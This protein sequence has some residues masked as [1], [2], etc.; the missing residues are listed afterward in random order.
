MIIH[1]V[2][3]TQ[4]ELLREWKTILSFNE[5]ANKQIPT[6]EVDL[7]I[8]DEEMIKDIEEPCAK[9]FMLLMPMNARPQVYPSLKYDFG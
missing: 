6:D 1:V 5:E 7:S 2:F 3:V 9:S 8:I 4:K